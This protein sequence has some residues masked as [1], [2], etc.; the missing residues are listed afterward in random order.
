L[1]INY[2]VSKDA[3]EWTKPEMN[4][5]TFQG[6]SARNRFP[7][8]AVLIHRAKDFATACRLAEAWQAPRHQAEERP[9]EGYF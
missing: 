2:A 7:T 6:D 3:L 9:H 5:F 1:K 8:G 4:T